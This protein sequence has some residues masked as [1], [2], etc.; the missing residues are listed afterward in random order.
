MNRSK[1]LKITGLVYIVSIMLGFLLT[2]YFE[3]FEIII[4]TLIVDVIITTIIFLF[5]LRLN[6]SS[7]YDP[8]W[9]ILPPFIVLFW[10]Y[11]LD[12]YSSLVILVFIGV[13]LWSVRLTRN[14]Y[15]DFHGYK[16]E[17]FRYIDFRKK[18]KKL[19]WIVSYIGIHMFPT[20]IVL[21]GLFPIYF[22]VGNEIIY[23]V[24]IYIGVLIMIL[25]TTIS[26]IADS[27]LRKHK[28]S[29]NK[30]S[31]RT[32]LWKYSRHP[33]YF[34]EVLF[35]GGIY[36]VSIASGFHFLSASGFI[37]MLILFNFYSVP[38]MEQKLLNNKQDYKKIVEDIPRFF[39]RVKK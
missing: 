6:N 30:D 10:M 38:K 19:Y 16:Y 11:K 12:N 28:R 17:D 13:I 1:S 37:A 8:Y 21:L 23:S 15:L 35:W 3:T 25:A 14:W 18:F 22:L 9:S 2:D 26:F 27:Q 36:V 39:L 24:F 34:G 20:L 33:S 4:S 29:G 32:G 31:I 7:I 5:S